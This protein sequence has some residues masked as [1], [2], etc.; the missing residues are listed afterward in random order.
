MLLKEVFR[1][2][3]FLAWFYEE[4]FR[5]LRLKRLEAY[6]VI[7][8]GF[9]KVSGNGCWSCRSSTA[10][11]ARSR[12]PE[13]GGGKA[14]ENLRCQ[15]HRCAWHRPQWQTATR[16]FQNFATNQVRG[17]LLSIATWTRTAICETTASATSVLNVL[18][19]TQPES[20]PVMELCITKSL[21]FPTPNLCAF[22]T[23]DKF[24]K[25]Y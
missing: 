9:L 11:R 16:L 8:M 24:L 14:A 4:T 1:I 17:P 23:I 6:E 18:F 13:R 25:F 10:S 21:T 2:Y 5:C 12:T 20:S 22:L 19:C 3:S 7:E 15:S